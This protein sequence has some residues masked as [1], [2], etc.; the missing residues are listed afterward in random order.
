MDPTDDGNWHLLFSDSWEGELDGAY[1]GFAYSTHNSGGCESGEI[2]WAVLHLEGTPATPPARPAS[3][4]SV[5]VRVGDDGGGLGYGRINSSRAEYG[6]PS[7]ELARN[8]FAVEFDNWH[9]GEIQNEGDGHPSGFDPTGGALGT[10]S[11]Q[12]HIGL[13]VNGSLWSVQRNIEVGVHDHQLPDIYQP[14]GIHARVLYDHGRVRAWVRS[15]GVATDWSLVVDSDIEPLSVNS[16][17]AL[18][19]FTASTGGARTI[20]TVDNFEMRTLGDVGTSFVR[21]DPDS[22]GSIALTDGI[23]VLNALF[24]GGEIAC[25]DAADSDDSGTINLTDGVF[26]FRWLF[27]G[28]ASPPPPTP[29]TPS[30][31]S[32]DCGQD[33]TE[34]GLGCETGAPVCS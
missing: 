3:P 15:N 30:Y 14:R 33:P 27:G 6:V 16:S 29:S 25:D 20:M 10:G 1:L 32:S 13:N 24:R 7:K 23:V 18:V 22:G 28:G 8:S 12:Y 2:E 19:G 34:D 11:G 9:G 5:D 21:A 31:P 4:Y 17:K 26:I